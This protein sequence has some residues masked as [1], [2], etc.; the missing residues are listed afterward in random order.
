VTPIQSLR[1]DPDAL[2]AQDWRLR[3]LAR[4]LVQDQ[5]ALDDIV[6]QTWLAALER[7]PTHQLALR[8]WLARV[9]KNFALKRRVSERRRNLRERNSARPERVPSTAEILERE[10]ARRS[11]VDAVLALEEPYRTTLVLRYFEDRPPRAIA[12]RLA[13]PVETVRTRTRRAL[14]RLREELDRR[15][16][17]D[18]GQ[19]MR[20]LLPLASISSTASL[21]GGLMGAAAQL[22]GVVLV[23]AKVKIGIAATVLV[24]S[25]IVAW[26]LVM[27]DAPPRSGSPIVTGSGAAEPERPP[28]AASAGPA[29]ALA[30]GSPERS[31]I[32]P[33]ETTSAVEESSLGS[34]VVHTT[35]R[36]G[37]HAAR[38][39]VRLIPWGEPDPFFHELRLVSDARGSCRVDRLSP[40]IVGVYTN[41]ADAASAKVESGKVAEV[42]IALAPGVNVRGRVVTKDGEPVP[43]ADLWLSDRGN[44]EDGWLVSTTDAEGKFDLDHVAD[45]S[46]I[47]ARAPGR[48]P[49]PIHM[50]IAGS[51]AVID[52]TLVM[53]ERGGE[54]VGRVLDPDGEPMVGAKLRLSA[55]EPHAMSF[56]GFEPPCRSG[57]TEARGEFHLAGLKP[58]PYRLDVRAPRFAPWTQEVTIAEST[59]VVVQLG[60]AATVHGVVLGA[61]GKPADRV[62]VQA[63]RD[64]D[65][66]GAMGST[67]ADG[68]FCLEGLAPGEIELSADGG[69]RGTA[70]AT[71]TTVAGAETEWRPVLD[72]GLEIRG[73]VVDER[74]H[75]LPAWTIHARPSELIAGFYDTRATT[76]ASGRFSLKNL[77]DVRH[78]LSVTAPNAATFAVLERVD[79]R[80]SRDELVLRIPDAS[81][82]SCYITGVVLDPDGKPIG[83]ATV[84]P[85]RAEARTAP[86]LT[87]EGGTGKF[88]IGPVAPGLIRLAI[89]PGGYPAI[90]REHRLD[91]QETW[92]LGEVRAERPASL[93]VHL[94]RGQ[95]A[96]AS[97]PFL[98]LVPIAHVEQLYRRN[99]ELLQVSGDVARSGDLNPGSYLLEVGGDGIA[100]ARYAVELRSSEETK[101]DIVLAR[102]VRTTLRFELPG[103]QTLG[104]ALTDAGGDRLAHGE[105]IPQDPS[106]PHAY[107]VVLSLAPGRYHVT[108]STAGGQSVAS[109]FTVEES[110]GEILVPL[111]LE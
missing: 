10:A 64:G 31:T 28:V 41:L 96:P 32:A 22:S 88:R 95:G 98:F 1:D 63:G 76:D 109:D 77:K 54:L 92:D 19:W 99:D 57:R 90:E 86:I 74:D 6:Q 48:A 34:L 29:T 104:Y 33:A 53:G 91:Q 83:N 35:W 66:M 3:Q 71:V 62:T 21:L 17:G 11:V 50:I 87:T 5:N 51:G 65:F 60:E 25:S 37:A 16:G 59:S 43:R 94:R 12:K 79:V 101:V 58:G 49:S 4:Q 44:Y 73:R 23:T 67:R 82:P 102:G 100:L 14:E 38:V 52:L 15:H 89:R 2:L 24:V 111:V 8:S 56:D 45:G 36:D 40:G 18:R 105:F 78:E 93:V 80:P 47:G 55:S 20:S 110:A 46:W 75:A 72:A 70:T 42:T 69:D 7:G 61:A 9:V 97:A 103:A 27:E 13:L 107:D 108:G 84:T 26:Y 85:S 39:G 81:I 68:S 106:A 30:P